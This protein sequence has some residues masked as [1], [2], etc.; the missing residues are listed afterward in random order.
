MTALGIHAALDA[1]LNQK[2]L[3]LEE[4]LVRYFSADYRQRTNGHWDDR[5]GFVLHARKLRELV[6]SARIEVLE[7]L[8]DGDRY[9]DRHRVHVRKHDG[10]ELVQEVYLFAQLDGSGRF[11]RVE[12]VTLMLEGAEADRHL[13]SA[14]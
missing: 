5:A 14:K 12:E 2:H 4:V 6:A 10:T 8:C 1:L 9:A 7:E 11:R 13:G 3:P